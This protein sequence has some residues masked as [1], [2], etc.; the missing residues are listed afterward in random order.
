MSCKGFKKSL[1]VLSLLSLGS[2]SAVF[3]GCEILKDNASKS[4]MTTEGEELYKCDGPGFIKNNIYI[5]SGD[6]YK[7]VSSNKDI[8]VQSR[9]VSSSLGQQLNSPCNCISELRDHLKNGTG[10]FASGSSEGPKAGAEGGRAG[11]GK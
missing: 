10:R 1:M 7:D 9:R 11:E 4:V 3:A 8:K 6:N 5:K 2:P